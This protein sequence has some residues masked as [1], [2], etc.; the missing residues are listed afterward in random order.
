M[1]E[2]IT[3]QENVSLVIE[4][5]MSGGSIALAAASIAGWLM[6][7]YCLSSFNTEDPQNIE[8][9]KRNQERL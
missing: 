5:F 4:I 2:I 7:Y 3:S 8:L 9:N 1:L 6:R